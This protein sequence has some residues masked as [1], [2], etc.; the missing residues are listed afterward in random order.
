MK[1]HFVAKLFISMLIA[2]IAIAEIKKDS[3]DAAISGLI[4][5]FLIFT[6]L[7]LLAIGILAII[8]KKDKKEDNSPL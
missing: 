7:C 8:F 6:A 4:F 1:K 5:M 2:G 3:P